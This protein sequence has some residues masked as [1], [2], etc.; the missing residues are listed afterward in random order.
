MGFIM[1]LVSC[2]TRAS[3]NS[4]EDPL[5]TFSVSAVDDSTS[6]DARRRLSN[7]TSLMRKLRPVSLLGMFV[8]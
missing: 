1:D 2:E 7:V 4:L 3:G 8:E 5:H 6:P